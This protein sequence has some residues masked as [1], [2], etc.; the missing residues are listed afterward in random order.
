MDVFVQES[1]AYEISTF[2]VGS[3]MGM[4][5]S[6]DPILAPLWSSFNITA[7][8]LTLLAAALLFWRQW[9]MARTLAVMAAAGVAMM[10][11]T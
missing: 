2:L 11:L 7:A 5:D 10:P 9:G 1:T 8:L 6:G 4:I 3:G